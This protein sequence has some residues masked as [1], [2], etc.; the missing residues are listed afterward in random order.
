M[1]DQHYRKKLEAR[2]ILQSRSIIALSI[3]F[4]CLSWLISWIMARLYLKI[5]LQI[6]LNITH[7]N[8]VKLVGTQ[9]W[10]NSWII[11]VTKFAIYVT[12]LLH[13][14]KSTKNRSLLMGFYRF[15]SLDSTLLLL[16]TCG[17][18]DHDVLWTHIDLI[19]LLIFL[20]CF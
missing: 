17:R 12:L 7:G 8:C 10:L 5:P 9:T 3:K 1:H 2:C 4:C 13:L 15:I 19:V 6:L 11:S 20:N 18:H 16:Y 14:T